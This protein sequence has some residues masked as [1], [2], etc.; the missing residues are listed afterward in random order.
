MHII[1][2]QHSKVQATG[3]GGG[4]LGWP[5]RGLI[6]TAKWAKRKT[7]IPSTLCSPVP[8]IPLV[9]KRLLHQH[10]LTNNPLGMIVGSLSLNLQFANN[11][12]YNGNICTGKGRQNQT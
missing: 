5:S 12:D 4:S 11:K 6:L 2:F 10:S 7:L 1:I 8:D 3:M 9:V